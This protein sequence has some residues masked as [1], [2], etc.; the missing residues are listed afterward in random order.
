MQNTTV[1]LSEKCHK[2][3]MLNFHRW[4]LL[5]TWIWALI[6][7]KVDDFLVNKSIA[8]L[9]TTSVLLALKCHNVD[10]CQTARAYALLE[11]SKL[12]WGKSKL[13]D[14]W[15]FHRVRLRTRL[16]QTNSTL[17]RR[18]SVRPMSTSQARDRLLRTPTL[19]SRS[20]SAEQLR[21]RLSRTGT[22]LSV[23][24]VRSRPQHWT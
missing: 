2:Y 10:I 24:T 5:I 7:S 11:C 20:I 23:Q 15:V 9:L 6:L 19:R 12:A 18:R 3:T 14:V 17:D 16:A 21:E 4:A 8:L 13:L 1:G 22:G